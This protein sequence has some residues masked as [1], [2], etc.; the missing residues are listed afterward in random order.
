MLPRLLPGLD[1]T[2]QSKQSQQ[3]NQPDN[4]ARYFTPATRLLPNS[5]D[6][7]RLLPFVTIPDSQCD[8][9]AKC[10]VQRSKRQAH[11][12]NM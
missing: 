5:R 4:S 11:T 1:A 3:R 12:S 2:Q 9:Q 6:K 7:F 8:N 10:A